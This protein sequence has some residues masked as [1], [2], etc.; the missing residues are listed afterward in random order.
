M[1]GSGLKK[2]ATAHSMTVSSG[3]AY[4]D[5]NGYAVT[6]CEGSGWKRLAVATKFPSV[7]AQD[8]FRNEL[9]AY[10]LNRTY[11]VKEINYLSD[12]IDV[13][14]TD[15]MGTM[16]KINAFID[17]FFPLLKKYG[18]TGSDICIECGYSLGS[19]AKWKLMNGIIALPMHERCAE[20]VKNELQYEKEEERLN[21][22]GN[23]ITG[24]I[25]AFVGAAVG[26]LLWALIFLLGYIAAPVAFVI[27]WLANKGY[28]LLKG[29]N[30][31]GKIVILTLAII[32]GV[33]LGDILGESFILV[34]MINSGELPGFLVS[35][36]PELI[37]FV[38]RTDP[39]AFAPNL[40][41]GLM[42]AALGVFA[43]IRNESKRI[44]GP[45][46]KDLN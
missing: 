45:V 42:F 1:I 17:I 30:D 9:S 23:Y 32:F 33:V 3:V 29:K 40:L 20:K 12:G 39:M 38:F 2:L 28:G 16:K 34:S 6:L 37:M 36:V 4:G 10:N 5:M 8:E 24:A 25:G 11:R 35:D 27:G 7:T 21:D 14:F 19:E 31:K 15:T 41:M 22:T 26:S 43:L 46:L 13:V 44:S 18:A